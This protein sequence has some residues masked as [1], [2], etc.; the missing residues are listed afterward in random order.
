MAKLTSS[1]TSLTIDVCVVDPG[2]TTSP[3][4]VLYVLNGTTD[5]FTGSQCTIT[6][7]LIGMNHNWIFPNSSSNGYGITFTGKSPPSAGNARVTQTNPHQNVL[8]Y[9]R[10]S[11]T[12]TAKFPFTVTA[13]RTTDGTQITVD[14][15]VQDGP[16]A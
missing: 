5:V 10:A 13:Q 8:Q 9:T 7:N 4:L 16:G 12:S 1:K 15:S 14:P 2:G 6:F 3:Y 11:A